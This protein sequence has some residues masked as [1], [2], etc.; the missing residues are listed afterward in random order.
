MNITSVGHTHLQSLCF[1]SFA[2]SFNLLS[3]VSRRGY[4]GAAT[5]RE[6]PTRAS[7]LTICKLLTQNEEFAA[8]LAKT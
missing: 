8:L 7:V 3:S 4:L 6:P 5:G 2:L 1:G